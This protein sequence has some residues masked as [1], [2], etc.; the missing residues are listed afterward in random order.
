MIL[1]HAILPVRSGSEPDF[2]AAFAKARPL[3]ADQPG[4]R[5]V[6]LSR[7]IESPNLYLLLIEWDSVEAHT[8]GFRMSRE[9]ESW[10]TLLHHFYNPFPVVE[11]FTSVVAR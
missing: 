8:D 7:S 9:Y 1:E 2:E 10:K 3:V 11:H 5:S 6:S 4:C